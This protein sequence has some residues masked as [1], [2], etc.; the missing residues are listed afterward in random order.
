MAEA[1]AVFVIEVGLMV[2]LRRVLPFILARLA[3]FVCIDRTCS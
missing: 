3:V 1:G 2:L